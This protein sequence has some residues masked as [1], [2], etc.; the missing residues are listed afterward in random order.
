ML[1]SIVKIRNVL[2]HKN[3]MSDCWV[4]FFEYGSRAVTHGFRDPMSLI[5]DSSKDRAQVF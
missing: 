2:R 4:Q 3:I 1:R 5:D